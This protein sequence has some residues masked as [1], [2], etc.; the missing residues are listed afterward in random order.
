MKTVKDNYE[1]TSLFNPGCKSVCKDNQIAI[2]RLKRLARQKPE[3][4]IYFSGEGKFAIDWGDGR[5]ENL[6][7][8]GRGVRFKQNYSGRASR[9]ITISGDIITL[10]CDAN[11]L[12]GLDLSKSTSLKNLN[13][14]L[15]LLTNLDVSKNTE[16]VSLS[17]HGNLL[18]NLDVSKNTALKDLS[19]GNSR[20]SDS[21]NH[22]YNKFTSEAYNVLFGTLHSNTI[23]KKFITVDKESDC[24]RKIATDKGWEVRAVQYW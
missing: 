8:L 23:D 3:V 16:L 4:S 5:K 15:N 20:G 22:G 12:T 21:D 11:E 18:T 2:A 7:L 10:N 1:G 19:V 6:T 13:C 14:I 17:C 9:T 24:D